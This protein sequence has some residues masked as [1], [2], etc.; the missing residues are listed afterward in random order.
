MVALLNLYKSQTRKSK[1]TRAMRQK[2]KDSVC[3]I[4]NLISVDCKIC[5]LFM[6]ITV[7]MFLLSVNFAINQVRDLMIAVRMESLQTQG[8]IIA[9]AIASSARIESDSIIVDSEQLNSLSGEVGG[10]RDISSNLSFSI[11]SQQAGLI[12]RNLLRST[13][14]YGRVYDRDGDL[15]LDSRS[16]SGSSNILKFE[17]EPQKIRASEGREKPWAY[18]KSLLNLFSGTSALMYVDI[19]AG[20]GKQ[21]LEVETALLGE[22]KALVRAGKLNKTV[23]SVGIPIQRFHTIRGVLLLTSFSGDIDRLVA[24]QYLKVIEFFCLAVLIYIY[25]ILV[26][27]R[28]NGEPSK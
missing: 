25:A 18:V 1:M 11:N 14:T 2:F 15:L 12:L 23:I 5:T 13:E 3:Q 20:N 8:E 7:L 9:A 4:I 19:G 16:A 22:T 21:Y 28:R 24:G 26:C 27:I 10:R 6:V 17:L